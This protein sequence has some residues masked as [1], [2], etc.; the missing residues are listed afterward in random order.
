[1]PFRRVAPCRYSSSLSL[2]QLLPS[3]LLPHRAPPQSSL[4][5]S[6]SRVMP[7]RSQVQQLLALLS[8]LGVLD[9]LLRLLVRDGTS[10][11]SSELSSSDESMAAWLNC[12]DR[13]SRAS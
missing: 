7:Y 9:E 2:E 4:T 6:P 5:R 13:C 10:L 12:C 8:E 1:M 3:S 11:S